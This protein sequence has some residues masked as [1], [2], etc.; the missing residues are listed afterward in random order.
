MAKQCA[1]EIR[2]MY[3]VMHMLLGTHVIGQCSGK[4][5]KVSKFSPSYAPQL[6]KCGMPS[7]NVNY[8]FYKI[9]KYLILR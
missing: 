8:V 7:V 4:P 9:I 1:Y 2:P 3:S 6:F 5:I